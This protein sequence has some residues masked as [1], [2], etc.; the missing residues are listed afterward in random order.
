MRALLERLSMLFTGGVIVALLSTFA[1]DRSPI[2]LS[3]CHAETAES[4]F[5][6][7]WVFDATP[8]HTR[9]GST[10]TGFAGAWRPQKFLNVRLDQ[11]KPDIPVKLLAPLV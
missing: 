11:V 10:P 8:F 3:A 6:S 4:R 9:G 5:E 2:V 1:W 7:A